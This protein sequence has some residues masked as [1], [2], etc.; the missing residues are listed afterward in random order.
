MDDIEDPL[1]PSLVASG[2]LRG[3]LQGLG[4]DCAEDGRAITSEGTPADGLYYL[5]PW[6]RA[7]LGSDRGF[8]VARARAE[9]RR[10]AHQARGVFALLMF[11]RR[12]RNADDQLAAPVT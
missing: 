2:W 12:R 8:R 9:S 6:L 10:D 11:H 4:I 7:R 5:G 3:D 1:L